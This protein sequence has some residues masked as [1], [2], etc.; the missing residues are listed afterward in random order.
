[1]S[2]RYLDR[3][4]NKAHYDEKRQPLLRRKKRASP[5]SHVTS[6]QEPDEEVDAIAHIITAVQRKDYLRSRS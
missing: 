5:E 3:A 6:K 4:F 1:M 2:R